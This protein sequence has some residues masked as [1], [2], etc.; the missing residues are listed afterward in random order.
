MDGLGIVA[1]RPALGSLHSIRV[2][3]AFVRVAVQEM[4]PQYLRG[5]GELAASVEPQLRGL[6]AELEGLLERLAGR[7]AEYPES[8]LPARLARLQRAA[9]RVEMLHLLDRIIAGHGLVE[10]RPRLR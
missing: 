3:L 2:T 4:S 10:L 7:L 5:Y 1:D 9:V 6:T 8:S